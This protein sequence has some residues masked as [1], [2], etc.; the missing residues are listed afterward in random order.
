VA[1]SSLVSLFDPSRNSFGLLRVLLAAAVIVSHAWPL[2]GFGPDPGRDFNNL[3]I[4]AVECFFALSGFLIAR[5]GERLSVG[6]FVWHRM[7]RIFPGLWVALLVVAVI[8]A[9][10]VW[11]ASHPLSEYPFADPSPLAYLLNNVLLQNGQQAIGD[12]LA[13][14]PFPS[15]WNGPLYTLPFEFLCYLIVA[16]L[17]AFRAL[18]PRAVAILVGATWLL[19]QAQEFGLLGVVDTRQ[20]RFTL[21]FF[22]GALLY[23]WREQLLHRGRWWIPAVAAVVCVVSYL[24]W[25]F[26]QVGLFALAYL[27]IWVGAV[28]P[29]HRIGTRRDY[30]YG[31]YIYG[32][33]VLQLATF[34]GLNELGLP[35]YLAVVLLGSLVLAMASWHLIESRALRTKSMSL[36]GWLSPSAAPRSR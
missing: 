18:G 36:P 32:W 26:L 14:N 17:I 22:A 24:T 1:E 28:L 20:A 2:G 4:L 30:S 21:M 19:L 23:L 33:P 10:I 8:A 25:G 13:S 3:G 35:I 15:M 31:L 5:S 16:A 27:F 11:R 29:F 7:V 9:P 12:T 6:R 34:W